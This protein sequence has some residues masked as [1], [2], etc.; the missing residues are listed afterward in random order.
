MFVVKMNRYGNPENHSYIEGLYESEINAHYAGTI[1]EYW[2]G[3][4]YKKEII[5]F[6]YHGLD[7]IDEQKEKWYLEEVVGKKDNDD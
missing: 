2:R 7:E 5:K 6:P 1:E 3:G 4:K